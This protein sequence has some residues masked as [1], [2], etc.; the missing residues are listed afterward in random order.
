[1]RGWVT[2]SETNPILQPYFEAYTPYLVC[3]PTIFWCQ[4]RLSKFDISFLFLNP[5]PHIPRM[6]EARWELHI[7]FSADYQPHHD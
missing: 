2:V 5:Y 4:Q 6:P 1:M 7:H 3:Y